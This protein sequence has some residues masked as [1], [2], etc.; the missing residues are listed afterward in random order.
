M[1]AADDSM[2]RTVSQMQ[3]QMSTSVE[4][5][6]TNQAAASTHV[7]TMQ[8]ASAAETSSLRAQLSTAQSQ[9]TDLQ[10]LVSSVTA[11]LSQPVPAFAIEPGRPDNGEP[12]SVEAMGSDVIITAPSGGVKI[13][14][15]D[16]ATVDVCAL[17]RQIEAVASQLNSP[18]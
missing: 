2:E 9:L 1:N 18:L 16:C 4:Q 11:K 5:M 15:R 7:S 8:A 12:P 14:S 3:A 17:G 10:A 6:S 13:S